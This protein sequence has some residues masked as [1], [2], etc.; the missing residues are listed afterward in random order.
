MSGPEIKLLP[1]EAV[2]I[3]TLAK[4]ND[5]GFADQAIDKLMFP[6]SDGGLLA[7]H[8]LKIFKEDSTARF[9]KAVIDGQIVGFT[10]W[11][12]YH[13]FPLPAEAEPLPNWGPDANGVLADLFFGSMKRVRREHMAGKKCSGKYS[14][15]MIRKVIAKDG[16]SPFSSSDFGHRSGISRKRSWYPSSPRWATYGRPSRSTSMVGGFL[17][18]T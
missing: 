14:S 9:M 3:P 1:V 13:D 18:R 6:K 16:F 4:I 12:H 15:L 11:H 7:S 8:M 10:Q 17:K 5:I 2:D